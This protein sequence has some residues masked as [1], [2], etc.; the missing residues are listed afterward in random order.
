[1]KAPWVAKALNI[2]V[3]LLVGFLLTMHHPILAQS[4]D[5]ATALTHQAIELSHQGHYS[6]AIPLARRA[7]AIRE[8]RLAPTIP[9]LRPH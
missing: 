7:L 6:E 5:E 8:K 9:M 4:L 1:M 2:T 3:I